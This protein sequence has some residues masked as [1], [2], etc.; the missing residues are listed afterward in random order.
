MAKKYN[1]SWNAKRL[2]ISF[3][4]KQWR[5]DF[6]SFVQEKKFWGITRVSRAKAIS[7]NPMDR[8]IKIFEVYDQHGGN[9]SVTFRND[10]EIISTSHSNLVKQYFAERGM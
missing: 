10:N 1:S 9:V 4:Q 2:V 5:Q 7:T 8:G 3:N 6:A